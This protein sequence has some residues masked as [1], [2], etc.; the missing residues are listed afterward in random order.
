MEAR[1]QG[2]SAVELIERLS[3]RL[4]EANVLA[5]QPLADHRPEQMQ[6]WVS[7]RSVMPS[8][9]KSIAACAR[10]YWVG[11]NKH[12]KKRPK[13]S[14]TDLLLTRV[15]AL[16]PTWLLS[17]PIQ[18]ATFGNSPVYQGKLQRLAGPQRL[19]ATGWLMKSCEADKP[20]AI[21]DYFIYRNQQG[22]LLWIYSERL[23]ITPTASVQ[24]RAWYLHGFFA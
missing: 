5:W 17:E 15:E 24:P 3:A 6:R 8:A 21:R 16:Y 22:A 19:E 14:P 23:A 2:D 20:P 9:I 13:T 7:A 1:Q 18:L 4:G 10:F 12:I 11:G